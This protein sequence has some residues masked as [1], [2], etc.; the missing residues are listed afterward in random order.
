MLTY[1]QLFHSFF[2][3][4]FFILLYI[5][6][7]ISTVTK[8]IFHTVIHT[9]PKHVCLPIHNLPLWRWNPYHCFSI[10]G[11]LLSIL[12]YLLSLIWNTLILMSVGYTQSARRITSWFI[13]WPV[14][15]RRSTWPRARWSFIRATAATGPVR[16][17]CPQWSVVWQ[18]PCTHTTLL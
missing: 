16:M 3:P 5:F 10:Y 4:L 17:G 18:G 13:Q 11:A 15:A 12:I 7:V 2:S 8:I 6:L 14:R 9:L 1:T